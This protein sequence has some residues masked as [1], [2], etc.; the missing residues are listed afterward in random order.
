[1]CRCPDGSQCPPTVA[2]PP[3]GSDATGIFSLRSSPPLLPLLPMF[4]GCFL[5]P[6]LLPLLPVFL[7]CF[8]FSFLSYLLSHSLLPLLPIFLS[9]FLSPLLSPSFLV[10]YH[11]SNIP[12]SVVLPLLFVLAP[13][14]K[15]YSRNIL[16]ICLFLAGIFLF[17]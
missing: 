5:S 13:L 3:A 16:L 14:L 8:L 10:H 2:P 7:R 17:S 9:S 6:P 12:L 1:M 4:L 15:N 11:L